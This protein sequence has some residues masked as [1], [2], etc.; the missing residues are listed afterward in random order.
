MGNLSF[1]SEVTQN[2]F[3]DTKSPITSYK[4]F[5]ILLVLMIFQCDVT[6]FRPLHQLS[7]NEM[8]DFELLGLLES[9]ERALFAKLTSLEGALD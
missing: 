9:N 4:S 5:C 2:N 3:A 7:R 6:Y 1:S 8:L